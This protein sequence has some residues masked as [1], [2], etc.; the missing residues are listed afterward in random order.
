MLPALNA[1]IRKSNKVQNSAQYNARRQ[2]IRDIFFSPKSAFESYYQKPDL[3]GRDLFLLHLSFAILGGLMKF[4]GNLIQIFIFKVT[5]ID[6]ETNITFHQGVFSIFIFYMIMFFL[7]RLTDS[8][9]MYHQMRD[10]A[11]DWSG[12]EPHIFI[13]SFLPFSSTAVFWF[14]PPPFPLV[15]LGLGFLYSLQLS[16]IYLSIQRSWSS[17]DF[18][19]FFMK[20]ALFFLFL[21]SIPLF[22]YHVARTVLN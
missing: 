4:L 7:F 2:L 5:T 20:A 21:L 15:F 3:G 11:R 14:L 13:L 19:F 17:R 10:K 22:I 12:P 6:E 16:Y 9:R 8:F 18:F 1:P